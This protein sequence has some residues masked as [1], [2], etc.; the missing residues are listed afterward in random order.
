MTMLG[1]QLDDLQALSG[2]LTTMGADVAT[3]R[4]DAVAT[5]TTVIT[6]VTEATAVALQQITAHMERL[7]ASVR[8]AVA[9][10]DSTQWTGANADRFR[11]GASDFQSSLVTGQTAT[12]EAF[13]S[14]QQSAS[15]MSDTL[16]EFVAGFSAALIQA[17]AAANDMSAAVEAQRSNLDN[18]MNLGLSIG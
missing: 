8:S 2:R 13:A 1:A 5:T 6:E 14:F 9:S 11:Q 18:V 12:R 10:V 16:Q 3:G 15:L 7:E 4:D 17:S